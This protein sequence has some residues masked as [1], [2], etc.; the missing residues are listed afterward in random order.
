[1]AV[2]SHNTSVLELKE[3][4]TYTFIGIPK[5]NALW[6]T[7]SNSVNSLYYFIIVHTS[8]YKKHR[9]FT[10]HKKKNVIKDRASIR[11]HDD[12]FKPQI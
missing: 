11:S 6:D 10:T 8:S 4:L 5:R 1:M 12:E 2:C 9:N 3:R 7:S